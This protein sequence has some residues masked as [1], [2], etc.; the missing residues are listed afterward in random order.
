MARR[1]RPAP[2]LSPLEH[3]VMQAVW[4]SGPCSVET[5]HAAVSRHRDLKEVT[6]RTVLRRLEQKG[7][8]QHGVEGRAYIYRAVEPPRSIAARAVRQLIDRFCNGSVEELVSGIVEARVL[9]QAELARLE[10]SIKARPRGATSSRKG[11]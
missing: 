8:L 7:H 6:T 2:A 10:E 11:R 4:S 5:V 3:E 9:S 1:N